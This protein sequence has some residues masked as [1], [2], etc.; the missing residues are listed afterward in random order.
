[1]Y[2]IINKKK[3]IAAIAADLIGWLVFTP[4][5]LLRGC[6]CGPI[7][8]EKVH[9]ILVIRTAYIGDVVMTLPLLKPLR[10]RFPEAE[11]DFLT[12]ESA[13]SVLENNPYINKII[14]YDPFWFYPTS[15][16]TYLKFIKKLRK[17]NKYDLLIEARADIRDLLFLVFPLK[18]LYKLSYNIGGGAYFL[19]HIVSFQQEYPHKIDYHLGIAK[20]LNCPVRQIEWG[21]YPT[22]DEKEE[23]DI[24]MNKYSI[25]SPFLA[26]HPGSRLVLKR[27]PEEKCAALYNLLMEKYSMDL[28]L[29]GTVEEKGMI[30][31]ITSRMA[32]KPIVLAGKVSLRQM[33]LILRQSEILVCNDSSPMHLAAAMQ[34]PIVAIFGPSNSRETGPFGARCLSV[35]KEMVCRAACD[36]NSCHNRQYNAC[37]HMIEIDDVLMSVGKLLDREKDS[38]N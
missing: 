24:L 38:L 11:I 7:A 31:R 4:F 8:A 25:H 15:M 34:T 27:W 18:S 28:V 37:M 23:N 22:E 13:K 36:E 32:K 35:E 30:D 20:Y 17:N 14:T 1:M 3:L 2:K 9:R 26:A 29:F 19:S 6:C 16:V 12:S 21:I 33:A 10:D 5:R